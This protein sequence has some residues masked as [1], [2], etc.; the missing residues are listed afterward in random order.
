[1]KIVAL[2]LSTIAAVAL[3]AARAS[4]PTF[5]SQ[6]YYWSGN[7]SGTVAGGSGV[8]DTSTA[9]WSS[10]PS[11]SSYVPWDNSG[12]Y[13]AIFQN[14]GGTVTIGAPVTVG[15]ITFGVSGYT[16]TGTNAI[17][18]AGGSGVVNAVGSA[19][20]S[21]VLTGTSQ[22]T[23]TGAGS[24]LILSGTNTYSGGTTLTAGRLIAYNASAL[25]SGTV[26]I[27]GGGLG[28]ALTTTVAN[29][30]T[31]ATGYIANY[32]GGANPTFTGHIT[33]TGATFQIKAN[34]NIAS[35]L[36]VTGGVTGAGGMILSNG[37]SSVDF[38]PLWISGGSLNNTGAITNSGPGHGASNVSA[39][40]GTNVTSVIQASPTSALILSAQNTYTG[41][42]LVNSGTLF[43]EG[44]LAAGSAVTVANGATLRGSGTI[45]G[46]VALNA[47]A[48]V[49]P[50][51]ASAPV[52]DLHVGGNFTWNGSAGA[53]MA[54]FQLD[55]GDSDSSGLVI[56]GTLLKGAAGTFAFDLHN[57]GVR[58]VYTLA[59]FASTTFDASDFSALNLPSGLA[60]LFRIVGGAQLEVVV[61]NDEPIITTGL[62]KG[63]QVTNQP[64]GT[65][66]SA[67]GTPQTGAFSGSFKAGK[68]TTPA[69]F[70][71]DGSLLLQLS[72]T[73]NG[74]TVHNGILTK[75]GQPSGDAVIATLKTGGEVT[76]RNKSVLMAGLAS[77]STAVVAQTGTTYA[78]MPA[79][80]TI[81]KFLA[82][83]G[84]GPDIYFMAQLGGV[85]TAANK[86]ALCKISPVSDSG[87]SVLV[88]K[89]DSVGGKTVSVIATLAGSPGTLA[90][91]RWRRLGNATPGDIGMRLT[92][93]DKSAAVYDLH[94]LLAVTGTITGISDLAGDELTAF[95]LPAFGPESFASLVS[96]S[97][98]VAT[99]KNV[100]LVTGS[101]SAS[102]GVLAQK[103]DPVS[104]D[105]NGHALTGFTIKSLSD[106]IV[107]ANQSVAFLLKIGGKTGTKTGIGYSTDGAAWSLLANAGA[108][109]PGGGHWASFSSLVL[110]KIAVAGP[111]FVGKLAVS[112]ADEV[113]TKTNV[114]LWG[115]DG[116]GT[117][118]LLLRTGQTVGGKTL[119]SFV[120]LAPSPGSIGAASGYDSHGDVTLMATFTDGT[121]ELIQVTP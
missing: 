95:G 77:G 66:S 18:L 60:A 48:A 4:V 32:G 8:W 80:V 117:L 63:A 51:S 88:R 2:L 19:T 54:G 45:G 98:S 87:P 11:G 15:D 71:P 27:I 81:A 73:V 96:L 112:V 43:V 9:H 44:S 20:I 23:K 97:G 35:S 110:P 108:T 26:S 89:G 67:F 79:G 114:G 102:L 101:D 53:A 40:I 5:S 84:N 34:S 33:L 3:P 100:A 91:E 109:A 38:A 62:L 24:D 85:A 105:A 58:G 115:A 50:G 65:V 13:G 46:S 31:V 56:S 70:A 22:L 120:A 121:Q 86:L 90:Q 68:K 55:N 14:A 59:T 25:G 104:L 36:T 118:Q 93:S 94:A 111:I 16:L 52:A 64:A 92:F 41:P 1:M 83:D 113:T 69:I 116:F 42:T 29:P 74:S 61:L 49:A 106:P 76:G 7:V 37:E 78:T 82:I 107:G 6:P 119:K 39:V 10:D 57:S 47:G 72:G 103:G 99:A 28:A 17:T 30:I 21:A 75:L 12:G